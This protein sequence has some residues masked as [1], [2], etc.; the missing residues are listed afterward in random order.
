MQIQDTQF[1]STNLV[2]DF[3]KGVQS[4][5]QQPDQDQTQ[6][7]I[8]HLAN[9]AAQQQQLMPQMMSQMIHL[10]QKCQLFS[11]NYN[12][13]P[14]PPP[15]QVIQPAQAQDAVVAGPIY[16]FIVCPM[17]LVPT[18]VL[19]VKIN[20][21]ATKMQQLLTIKSITSIRQCT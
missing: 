8:Q 18:Q 11:N 20:C 17:V 10:L 13:N 4:A 3:I 21:Q 14:H 7:V 2:Q 9:N 1:N 6:D 12:G 15:S 5:L 19:S 16:L